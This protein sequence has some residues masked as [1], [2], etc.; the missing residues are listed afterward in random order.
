MSV[1]NTPLPAEVTGPVHAHSPGRVNLIGDHTDYNDGLALPM[2]VD[3]G[4]DVVF[5]PDGRR[6]VVIRSDV[7][8]Q[9]AAVD[10]DV[11]QDPGAIRSVEPDWARYVAGIVSVVHPSTGGHGAIATTLPVGAGLSSSAALEVSLALALGARGSPLELARLCQSAEQVAT[12]VP[13]GLMDQLVV[14]GGIEG[15]AMLI[16]FAKLDSGLT[17]VPIPDSAEIIVV[18]SG[19]Q[20]SLDHSAYAARRAECEAAAYRLGPLGTVDPEAVLGLPDPVLRRRARHVV[21]ECDRVRWFVA[22]LGEEDLSEAGRL[23]TASH[24]SLSTDFEVS[25]PS[26]DALV[27]SLVATRGVYGARLTGAGFGGCVVALCEPGAIDPGSFATPAW[28]LRPSA[29]AW[30]SC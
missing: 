20:R 19:Q 23:M 5:V 13:T 15:C 29:G 28:R 17:P 3:L 18:H 22:A 2:A 7:E 1:G 4:T 30:V 12:G 26:L 25:T 14:S 27:Q 16:D 6:S 10:L 21:T 11:S 24:Y 9:P 8:A